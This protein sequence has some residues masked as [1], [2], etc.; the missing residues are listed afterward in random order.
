MKEWLGVDFD[1]TISE[2][3]GWNGPG[4]LGAPIPE[5]VRKVKWVLEN[6]PDVMVKIFTARAYPIVQTIYEDTDLSV[7]EDEHLEACVI[8]VRAIQVWCKEVFGQVLPIT[9]VKDYGMSELWDDRAISVTPNTGEFTN[10][11]TSRRW[12]IK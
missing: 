8:A 4:H 11:I 10:G 2:Y 9:C 3:K 6:Q 1:G 7:I 12:K 5:M